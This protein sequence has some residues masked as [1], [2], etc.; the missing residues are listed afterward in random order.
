MGYTY[1]S[2]PVLSKVKIGNDY[3]Y[4]KDKEIRSIIDGYNNSIVT[5][6][7][8]T[9]DGSDGNAFVRASGIKSYV[10]TK[11]SSLENEAQVIN[12]VLE[13]SRGYSVSNEILDLSL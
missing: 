8:G 12:E 6:T 9:V 1:S 3:Y 5:G 13:F 7:I 4:L 2:T 10:D 11:V